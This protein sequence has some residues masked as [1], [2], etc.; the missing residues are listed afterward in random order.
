MATNEL[1]SGFSSLVDL[2]DDMIDRIHG[3]G[4]RAGVK[5]WT[6]AALTARR[7]EAKAA[8]KMHKDAGISEDDVTGARNIANSN[9]KG[10]IAAARRMPL[11]ELAQKGFTAAK[12]CL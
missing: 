12:V 3:N 2:A 7:D 9:A 5:Q 1:P 11:D 4:D 8:K 6:E 10:F